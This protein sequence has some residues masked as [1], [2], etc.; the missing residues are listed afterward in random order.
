MRASITIRA[1]KP[2]DSRHE[3][4][5]MLHASYARLGAMGFNY[6]AVDQCE[7]VT[8]RRLEDGTCF[9]AEHEGRLAGTIAYK[10]PG[11]NAACAHYTRPLVAT[12]GQFAVLPELQGH[13]LGSRLLTAAEDLA[14]NEGAAELALDTAQGAAQLIGWYQKRGYRFIEFAQWEGKTYR[15]VILSKPLS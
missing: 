14:R 10:P 5:Q 7:D 11:I 4:T 1:L 15:S 2:S 9:V 6:T 12:I 8:R 13:G 3:L